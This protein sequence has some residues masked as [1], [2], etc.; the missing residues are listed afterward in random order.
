[1]P[2]RLVGHGGRSATADPVAKFTPNAEATDPAAAVGWNV[3][4][5]T[6]VAAKEGFSLL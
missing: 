5:D 2:P 3:A 4:A 1:M 6:A